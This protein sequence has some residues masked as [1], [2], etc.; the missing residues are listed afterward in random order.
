MV[1]PDKYRYFLSYTVGWCILVGEVS[2]A[3]GCALNSAEI[4]S[5]FVEITHPEVTWKVCLPTK[6]HE[7]HSF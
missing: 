4:V 2:V 3:A 7:K 6:K 5:T 1:A